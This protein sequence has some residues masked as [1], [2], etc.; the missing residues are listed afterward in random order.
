MC[1]AVNFAGQVLAFVTKN[2]LLL[3]TQTKRFLRCR[4]LRFALGLL[5]FLFLFPFILVSHTALL[6]QL[7]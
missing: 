1:V 5:R 6:L 4:R 3:R 7:V 2:C